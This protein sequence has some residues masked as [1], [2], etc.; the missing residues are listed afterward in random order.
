MILM[1]LLNK[2]VWEIE[3]DLL[4]INL[5][6]NLNEM[7]WHDLSTNIFMITHLLSILKGL[8]I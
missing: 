6:N 2:L 3:M 5:K 8:N 1:L 7:K 4:N